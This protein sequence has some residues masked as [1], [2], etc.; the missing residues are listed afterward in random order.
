M[1]SEP[2]NLIKNARAR[3]LPLGVSLALL[4]GLALAAARPAQAQYSFT[5]FNV[6]ITGA[7]ST[8][9]YGVNDSGQI[10]GSYATVS[11]GGLTTF[12]GYYGTTAT[13]AT[14]NG[15]TG[16]VSTTNP[17]TEI[18][19]INNAG[20]YVGDYEAGVGGL[21]QPQGFT[22][23]AGTVVS[24][25]TANSLALG[26]N[27]AGTTVGQIFDASGTFSQSYVQTSGGALTTFGLTGFG[28]SLATGINDAGV[29]V[30]TAAVDSTTGPTVS[31]V[32]SAGAVPAFSFL[33]IAGALNVYA[34]GI[35]NS[36]VI[37]GAYDTA[38]SGGALTG[39]MAFNGVETDIVFPTAASTQVNGINS[40]GQIV[41]TY[42]DSA[43]ALH[44]FIG[45]PAVP[46]ASTV[47]S[48]GL[49]LCLGLGGVVLS[50]RRKKA[51]P[52]S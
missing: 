49:L 41:G 43:G 9:I 39:F 51:S 14:V 16:L 3:R 34:Q 10:V 36:G 52:A 35:S 7:S 17:F 15:P 11:R 46:E 24:T 30:G 2:T 23:Y 21:D 4:S 26:I 19:K 12:H 31:Y 45:A 18:N 28:T 13:Q 47:A 20:A 6:G 48:L 8:N 50:A 29:I 42:T 33:N 1:I 5:A 27:N 25:A 44:G 22:G 32:R 37:V 38:Q 40:L